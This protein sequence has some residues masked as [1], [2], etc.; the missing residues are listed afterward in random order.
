[1]HVSV[2]DPHHPLLGPDY[3]W[4][5]AILAIGRPWVCSI[6]PIGGRDVFQ[7]TALTVQQAGGGL[8]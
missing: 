8:A 6:F 4:L 5:S 3:G 2:I 1:M 7:Q